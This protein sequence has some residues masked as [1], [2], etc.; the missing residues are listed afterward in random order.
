MKV[1]VL[2][3]YSS[4]KKELENF[5]QFQTLKNDFETQNFK[6]FD[7]V[8]HNFDKSDDVIVQ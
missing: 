7:K 4:Q 1:G 8:V 5:N 6:I 3:Q 2:V